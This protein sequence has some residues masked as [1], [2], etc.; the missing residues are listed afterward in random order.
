MTVSF[1]R[2]PCPESSLRRLDARWKLAGLTLAMAA[3]AAMQS[4]PPA[5]ISLVVGLLLAGQGRLPRSWI[6]ARLGTVGLVLAPFALTLPFLLTGAGPP[7][8]AWGWVQVSLHGST[9]AVALCAKTL[10]IA[11]LTL[12]LLATAPLD[13]TLKA[14]RALWVPGLL[15]QVILLTYRYVDV[16]TAELTQMRIAVRTRGYRNRPTRHSY[17]TIGNVA[18]TLLVRS[19]ER[20]ERVSQAMRCR[21]FDGQFR[22]LTEFRTTLPDVLF[23]VVLTV[24]FA[25]LLTWSIVN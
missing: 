11:T 15:V 13:A 19:A 6:L 17:H 22:S 7:L 10:A 1:A 20:A 25:A 4:W 12:V 14:A 23:F 9:A 8:F 3:V 18:G 16:V 21:G 24:V 2:I 5:V